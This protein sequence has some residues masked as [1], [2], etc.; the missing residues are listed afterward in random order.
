MTMKGKVAIVAG[1][2]RDIG[3]ACALEL[4]GRGA[5]VVITYLA[6]EATAQSAVEE[7][8]KL[9][10]RAVAVKADLTQQQDVDACVQSTVEQFGNCLLYTS[11][12]PRD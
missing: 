8:Q 12:S 11:P 6:S 4:A 1:G 7:I 2:G 3:R 9:G 10:V 5:D